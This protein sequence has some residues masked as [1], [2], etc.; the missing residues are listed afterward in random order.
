M[1]KVIQAILAADVVGG[2]SHRCVKCTPELAKS[3]LE[4]NTHNRKITPSVVEKYCREILNGEWYPMAAGIGVDD[5]GVLVD[6]QHRLMAIVETEIAVPLLIVWGLPPACQEKEDRHNRRDMFTVFSLAG[7]ITSRK[8]VQVATFFCRRKV[9]AYAKESL[10]RA[11]V[12]DSDVKAIYL[13]LRDAID[14]VCEAFRPI[15]HTDFDTVGVVAACVDGWQIDSEKTLRFIEKLHQ[16]TEIKLD[17]P[18]YR[19]NRWLR[20]KRVG[21]G[22]GQTA[23]YET[24]LFCIDAYFSGKLI[25]CLRRIKELEKIAVEA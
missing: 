23:D 1:S 6:G 16:P 10:Q 11:G 2:V 12:S 5:H 9:G 25:T 8:A 13:A 18:R 7:I 21:G 17:D 19:L 24:T 14:P 3:L 20:E 4:L 15:A 22:A